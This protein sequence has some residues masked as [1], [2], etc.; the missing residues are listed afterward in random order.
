MNGLDTYTE[1]WMDEGA[2]WRAFKGGDSMAFEHIYQ[3]NFPKLLSYGFKITADSNV[4]Q[5]CIQDLFVELWESRA[6]I[7]HVN[8][9]QFYLLKSLRYKVV[10]H[11]QNHH[12]QSLDDTFN[13]I[14]E[15][16]YEHEILKKETDDNYSKQL[17]I[18]IDQLPKRQKEALHL[19]Y[20]QDFSNEEVAQIMG[21]NYQSA[22]KFIY[23]ALKSLRGLM[24][25]SSLLPAIFQIFY[26]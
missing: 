2:L 5:D 24:R 11:L 20:F 17:Q 6:N 22:C 10:R 12:V 15:D 26:I 21:V 1:K 9:I 23:T 19:R 13:S 14:S 18:A 8:S 4:V 25:L 7:T 16:S 3:Q